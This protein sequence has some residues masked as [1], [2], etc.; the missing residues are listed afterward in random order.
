[1]RFAYLRSLSLQGEERY[2]HFAAERTEHHNE[3]QT[4]MARGG[5]PYLGAVV[6]TLPRAP[7]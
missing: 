1:M 2:L 4:P 6:R 7:L 3:A 5:L